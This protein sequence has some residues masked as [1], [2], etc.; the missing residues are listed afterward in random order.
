MFDTPITIIGNVLTAP[1]WRRTKTTNTFVLNFRMASTARRFDKETGQWVD[2]D[3]FRVRIVCWKRLA[4]NCASSLQLGDPV[5]VLGRIHT[6]DW[7]DEAD[8][9]RTS[10]EVEAVAVGHDL[11][12]GVGKFSRRKLGASADA[13]FDPSS[14]SSFGSGPAGPAALLGSA[15]P[16]SADEEV[17]A[18]FSQGF[19]P[20]S[21]ADDD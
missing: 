2:G 13:G 6:R 4:E 15:A 10:Y 19:D 18:D 21:E 17:F 12:R 11:S 5:M 14:E 3:S 16:L 20:G 1:E 8:Q 7:T 9:R